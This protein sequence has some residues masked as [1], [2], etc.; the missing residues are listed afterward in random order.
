LGDGQW[1]IPALRTLLEEILPRNP[2]F[3]D[4]EVNHDFEHIGQKTMLL[5]ARRF[6][7][8]G[9]FE[10]ILLAIEDITDRRRAEKAVKEVERRKEEFIAVLA[11]ELRNPLASINLAAR[12]VQRT[13]SEKDRSR[14]LEVL[15]HQVKSLNRLIEDLLD[16]SRLSKGKIHLRMETVDLASVISRAVESVTALAE[17]RGHELS[18]SVPREP[19]MVEGDPMR[20]EQVFGNLLTNA[21]KYMEK[22]GRITVTAGAEGG[23][24]I[25][26]VRDTGEGISAEMLP[27]L[28]EMF[29]QVESSMHRSR[30]GLGIG[31]SLA[32]TLV[33]MH[34]GSVQVASDGVGL[35]SEFSVRLPALV[36]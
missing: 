29:T 25:V 32:R 20:L 19:M 14:S 30:G 4:F 11:H 27:G 6:S 7:S 22:G 9:R 8:E 34:G 23:D 10:L 31:L 3:Q 13:V 12:L 21:C 18:V 15:V 24:L 2:S 33:E 1:D 28:F 36:G 5:N 26:R 16:V 35:G 17:E